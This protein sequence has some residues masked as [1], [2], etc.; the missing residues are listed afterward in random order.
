MT[1]KQQV[2][3]LLRSN[4][5]SEAG[6]LCS[7]L[8]EQNPHDPQAWFLLAGIHAQ[9]GAM[10]EVIRCCR[11]VIAL[12]SGNAAAHYNLGVALQMKGRNQ[13]AGDSYRR[14]LEV[15][16]DDV[17]ALANM[18]VVL[19]ELGR[20]EEAV[21]HCHRALQL[22]P[23]QADAQNTLG[24]IFKDQGKIDD[25]ARCFQQAIALRPQYAEAYYNLGL[26]HQ[27]LGSLTEA[28]ECFRQ[29]VCLRPDYAE[30]HGRLGSILALVDK[31]EDAV[32]SYEHL[33]QLKPDS[34]E[35]HN[36]LGVLL[37]S[38]RRWDEAIS[39]YRLAI[40]IRPD[41]AD[42]Y[43][44]LGSALLLKRREPQYFEEAA[45]YFRQ[46]IRHKPDVSQFHLNLA[47]ALTD[48]GRDQEAEAGYRRALELQ[49]DFPVATAGLAA[50]FEKRGNFDTGYALVKP[51]VDAGTT[52]I[53]VALSYA[54]LARHFAGHAHAA[55]LLESLLREPIEERQ[56]AHAHF[57]LGKLYD[58]MGEY[59]KAFENIQRANSLISKQLNVMERSWSFDPLIAAFVPERVHRRPRASNRSKLPVFIVGM[60]RSGTSLVEQILASHPLVYGAGE[61]RDISDIATRLQAELGS[62]R[63]YPLYMDDLT[64]RNIDPIA[65]GYLDRLGRFARHAVR[66][67][68]KMPHNFMY[69]GLIDTLLP[70]ARVIHC[71]RDPIDTCLSIYFQSFTDHFNALNLYVHDLRDLGI[72]YRQYQRLMAHWRTIL[73]IPML[74]VKY[75]ELVENQEA[76]SRRLV[77]FCELPWDERC[78]RFHETNRIVRTASYDQ[79]RRPMYKS[80]IKRWKH[81][82][83]FLGPLITT[84]EDQSNPQR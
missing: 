75:E 12:E 83:Q 77:E 40:G 58:E 45:E 78:L 38:L 44:K 68:D 19:R 67:T 27:A 52:N 73:R 61:L 31:L 5:F 33:V 41:F 64:R 23:G 14:V 49:P 9:L 39:H 30:A 15:Q 79:V 35:A 28:E 4:Q 74:E 59:S 84:L 55:A 25:A 51:L 3:S 37:A 10:D 32:R 16:P 42:A 53:Y 82:E 13:E 17:L 81:Y 54:R 66:V 50:V 72:F 69:L 65:Q 63:P 22:Q 20:H 80:S 43:D 57:M 48:L 62:S 60:P 8:C 46:A 34:A 56:Q 11:Q 18:G 47:G 21:R 71:M 7:A 2:L 26:C 76:V 36:D 1:D 6:K 70:G 24:L 29:A